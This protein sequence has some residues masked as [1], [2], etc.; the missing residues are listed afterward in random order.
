MNYDIYLLSKL[1]IDKGVTINKVSFES[2]PYDEQYDILPYIW[3]YFNKSKYNTADK[4][5]YE[6]IEMYLDFNNDIYINLNN[7]EAINCIDKAINMISQN[8]NSDFRLEENYLDD[9]IRLLYKSKNY[10]KK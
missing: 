7:Y 5:L 3:D 6:C 2:M 9:V 10:I 1:L 8:I 4:P